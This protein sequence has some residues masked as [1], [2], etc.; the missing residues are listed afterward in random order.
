[1]RFAKEIDITYVKNLLRSGFIGFEKVKK[2]EVRF[3]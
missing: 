3:V 1:M 2:C